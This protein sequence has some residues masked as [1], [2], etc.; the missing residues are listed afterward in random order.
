[1]DPLLQLRGIVKHFPGVLAN[2][3]IDL[4]VAAG[5][6]H[7]LLGENGAG[8]STLM[9]LV[10]GIYQPDAGQII[11][12]GE[13][14]ALRSPSEAIERGIGMVHQRFRLIP[15][16]TVA[17]NVM[18]GRRSTREPFF[19]ARAAGRLVQQ[20]A[21]QL[22]LSLDPRARVWQL[23]A[24]T[25]Q[26]VEII[27]ALSRGAELLILDEPTSVLTPQEAEHLF[28]TVRRLVEGGKA[29]C[30]I[31]HK[32]EEV[33]AVADRVTVLRQ[34]RVQCTTATSATNKAELA[35]WMVGRDVD[36]CLEKTEQ[37]PGPAV[38]QLEAVQTHG[39]R[40]Q[41]ALKQLTLAV[42]AG[43]IVGVA[44][45]AGNG[46]TELAEVISG[47]RP[48]TEG[49]VL[50]D[51]RD[52]AGASP[53]G[54]VDAGVAYIPDQPAETAT[55]ANFD[56]EQNI[57]LRSQWSEPVAR[58]GV[59]R[60]KIIAE[61]TAVL[62]DQFDVRAANGRVLARQLSGGNLQKLVLARELSRQPRLILA[63]NPTAGLDVGAREYV[64]CRLLE[65]RNQGKAILLISA[66]LD[67]VLALSDR[68]AVLHEGRIM[69]MKR[70][71]LASREELGL[72]MAGADH[73]AEQ[74]T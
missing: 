18:L 37:R 56:L 38:L 41:R 74:T 71:A 34:G 47:L 44:G 29:V 13:E 17:E 42:Q 19:D 26:W 9:N 20:L 57:I 69:G 70:A 32:L 67:E 30:L 58:G 62:L 60:P 2:D 8:K 35:R 68:I 72:M 54:I 24:G 53:R 23:P 1:M 50:I 14:L 66:D 27:R 12:R 59:L 39:D 61:R 16:L 45:V 40:Y 48:V 64:H 11:W 6:V 73:S 31:T 4:D 15:T 10:F 55:F 36:F 25:Q 63:V 3:H 52:V 65:E 28:V 49:R 21:A 51:G 7:A 5:E 33:M 22:D 43:E 46:Q